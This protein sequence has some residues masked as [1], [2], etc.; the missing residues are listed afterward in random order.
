MAYAPATDDGI[1]YRPAAADYLQTPYGSAESRLPRLHWGTGSPEAAIT[2]VIGDCYFQTDAPS[3]GMGLSLKTSGVGNT[4]WSQA[5]AVNTAQVWTAL[6][7]IGQVADAALN[8]GLKLVSKDAVGAHI[9]VLEVE[10]E[11]AST[12]WSS[13]IQVRAVPGM[14]QIVGQRAAGTIAS[15]T[16]LGANLPILEIGGHPYDGV[17]WARDPRAG[18]RFVTNELQTATARGTRQ[19]FRTVT[20]GTTARV[21]RMKLYQG[22]LLQTG[23]GADPTGGD[24]GAGTM[25]CAGDVYKNNSAYTNPDYVFEQFYLGTVLESVSDAAK[26]YSGLLGFDALASFLRENFHLP[27][28]SRDSS[29]IFERADMVLEKL[30]EAYLYI[31]QLHDRLEVVEA[32]LDAAGIG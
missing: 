10:S 23:A 21:L 16:A 8:P 20:N 15:P 6:Q 19:E 27:G 31:L 32:K 25:N 29:G 2:A 4:G 17:A 30:E 14:V 9:N 26:T 13:G 3:G 1:V 7:T 24:K 11:V 12:A 22:L 28:I 5:I 18:I